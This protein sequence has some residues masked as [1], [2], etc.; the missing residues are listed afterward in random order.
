MVPHHKGEH[1]TLPTVA[2]KADNDE[3]K[4]LI[5]ESDFDPE[6]HEMFDAPKGGK[7][8][9]SKWKKKKLTDALDE[10]KVKYDA[11]ATQAELAAIA[12]ANLE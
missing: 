9:Y 12:A 7:T 1:G 2:V 3:G 10:V 6:V 4:M 11:D 8:D 5:N